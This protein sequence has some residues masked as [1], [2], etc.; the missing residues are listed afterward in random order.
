MADR[1][2]LYKDAF[3]LRKVLRSIKLLFNIIGFAFHSGIGE[4]SLLKDIIYGLLGLCIDAGCLDAIREDT[5]E[6][7]L[8]S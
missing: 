7:L 3:T 4:N 6:R 8:C 2:V 1:T 5:A